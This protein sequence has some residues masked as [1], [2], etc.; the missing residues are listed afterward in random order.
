M[1]TYQEA[2]N[3]TA[4]PSGAGFVHRRR[5]RRASTT[6]P[7]HTRAGAMPS[8]H[9][10]TKHQQGTGN[11]LPA[12]TD[13]ASTLYWMEVGTPCCGLW[14]R[15]SPGPWF[16][17]CHLPPPCSPVAGMQGDTRH[18]KSGAR[19]QGEREGRRCLPRAGLLCGR[20]AWA[21]RAK[22]GSALCTPRGACLACL[23]IGAWCLGLGFRTRHSAKT[24]RKQKW[25]GPRPGGL[26]LRL[27]DSW[28]TEVRGW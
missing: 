10:H 7:A 24:T 18:A 14:L 22:A 1:C 21:R 12:G 4:T 27:G 15:K 9:V 3:E 28:G 13:G 23:V 16:P 11:W 19:G 20:A 2:T 17:A 26:T 25:S 6:T 8:H 5:R